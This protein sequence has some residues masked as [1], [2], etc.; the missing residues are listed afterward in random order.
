MHCGRALRA[1]V[2]D[3]ATPCGRNAVPL[4]SCVW[5]ARSVKQF[6]PSTD[7][8][9]THN[10]VLDFMNGGGHINRSGIMQWRFIQTWCWIEH[11][12][13]YRRPPW[14]WGSWNWCWRHNIIDISDCGH[15]NFIT[16][17]CLMRV[18]IINT[19]LNSNEIITLL[20][21]LYKIYI[22]IYIYIYTVL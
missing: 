5:I 8:C 14:H 2:A 12:H 9:F 6:I 7:W 22:Y 13:E 21:N 11:V 18:G 19:D 20:H 3:W 17:F 10:F 16:E 1:F 15:G 4:F